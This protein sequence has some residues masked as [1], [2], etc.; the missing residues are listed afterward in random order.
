MTTKKALETPTVHKAVLN[1][2][3]AARYLSVSL[4]TIFRLTR[5]GELAHLRIGRSLRYRVEDLDAFL[6]ERSTKEWTDFI[7]AK[8]R[9]ADEASGSSSSPA[10]RGSM[11]PKRRIMG[12]KEKPA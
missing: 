11:S 6:A 4:A 1:T 8:K 5:G 10:E 2:R 3:E 7:P 9:A 12:H